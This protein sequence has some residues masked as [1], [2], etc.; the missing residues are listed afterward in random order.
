M[1][2]ITEYNNDSAIRLSK[3]ER[4]QKAVMSHS[5]TLGF[6]IGDLDRAPVDA[7]VNI[8]LYLQTVGF[9]P[10]VVMFIY[11]FSGSARFAA[12]YSFDPSLMFFPTR[13]RLCNRKIH[14]NPAINSILHSA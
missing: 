6:A 10:R 13:F 14:V 9:I 8:A 4:R 3:L 7:C 1:K 2:P 11:A 5:F 12:K